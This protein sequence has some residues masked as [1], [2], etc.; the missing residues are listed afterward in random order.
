MEKFYEFEGILIGIGVL[1]IM[2]DGYG[3]FC[4]FDYNYFFLFDDIYVL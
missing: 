2:F 1:E 3:F 4:L